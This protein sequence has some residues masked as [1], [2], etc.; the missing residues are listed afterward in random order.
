[1]CVMSKEPFKF[2]KLQDD[3]QLTNKYVCYLEEYDTFFF[4]AEDKN[5]PVN[6]GLCPERVLYQLSRET[7]QVEVYLNQHR[8]SND[9]LNYALDK[10][11][12]Y[13]KR[14]TLKRQP[15]LQQLANKLE[16]LET[17]QLIYSLEDNSRN[18]AVLVFRVNTDIEVLAHIKAV[19]GSINN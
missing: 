1:M 8:M 11:F 19:E 7:V 2:I 6:A 4:H 10:G 3:P 17:G 9:Q 16:I 15:S 12:C 13:N 5:N 18:N 14:L